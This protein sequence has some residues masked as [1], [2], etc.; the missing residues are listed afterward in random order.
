MIDSSRSLNLFF[1]NNDFIGSFNKVQDMPKNNFPECCFVG[2]SNVGKSSIINSITKS[3]KLAK[4][5]NTPGRTQ[6]ANLFLINNKLNIIDLP[7]YGYAKVSKK[8]REDLSFL[9]D[10][11]IK[12]RKN[13]KKIYVVID[14]RL[15]IKNTDIDQLDTIAN[16]K[17]AFTIILSK[18]DKCSYEF[19]AK[20]KKSIFSLMEN[21]PNHF[22]TIYT[23]SNKK[24]NGILDVQ[25]DLFNLTIK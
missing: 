5:S 16:T 4:T 20:Q 11:Y 21:Y 22:S 7:G 2:R 8:T 10:S 25:K 18:I 1:S 19:I 12:N 14:C 17:N 15:G 13:L 6:S 24:N 23:C 3:K 9:I